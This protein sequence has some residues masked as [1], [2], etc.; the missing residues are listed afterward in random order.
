MRKIITILS[1][2]TLVSCGGGSPTVPPPQPTNTPV[3]VP[4]TVTPTP[5]ETPTRQPTATPTNTPTPSYTLN[6]REFF[7]MYAPDVCIAEKLDNKGTWTTQK[8]DTT[9]CPGQEVI[10]N[11]KGV[12][13]WSIEVFKQET[14]WIRLT[15]ELSVG[16]S[17]TS[18]GRIFYA[19]NKMKG[20]VWIPDV[21]PVT[22]WPPLGEKTGPTYYVPSYG[23]DK[24]TDGSV[25]T[26]PSKA[27]PDIPGDPFINR[28]G[29]GYWPNYLIDNRTTSVAPGPGVGAKSVKL[30]AIEEPTPCVRTIPGPGGAS[31]SATCTPTPG[32]PTATPTPTATPN[33]GTSPTPCM[34]IIPGPGGGS[35][36][37]PCTPTPGPIVST[38]TPTPTPTQ[39]FTSTPVPTSTPS[40]SPTVTPTPT[41]TFVGGSVVPGQITVEWIRLDSK[42]GKTH[43][44]Y[45]YGRFMDKDGKW[46]GL[47]LIAFQ[48]GEETTWGDGI[49]MIKGGY[50]AQH[51]V[52]CNPIIPCFR[53]P[54]K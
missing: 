7:T 2:I 52:N 12:N 44:Y 26:A 9:T 28:I 23:E 3:V 31:G 53:C 8:I 50:Y 33:V 54:D 18:G 51:L 38:P 46:K 47:G 13:P 32:G 11:M 40:G 10:L 42:M 15:Q 6:M 36:G 45:Y 21:F 30:A 19:N 25:C 14:P 37:I 22:I 20:V 48:W 39:A 43:E 1:L 34:V 24:Y 27:I 4:P 49:V 29:L 17:G 35:G 5:T 41:P 16:N